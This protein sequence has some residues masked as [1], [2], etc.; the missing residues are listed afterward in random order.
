[1]KIANYV[2]LNFYSKSVQN[3]LKFKII[4]SDVVL[5]HFNIIEIDVAK[6]LFK[7]MQI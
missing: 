6:F 4:N 2:L 7:S 1:M 5:H 3:V